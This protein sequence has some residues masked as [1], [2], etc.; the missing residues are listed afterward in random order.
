MKELIDKLFGWLGYVPRWY[1]LLQE[2]NEFFITNHRECSLDGLNY[3]TVSRRCEKDL[4]FGYTVTQHCLG[5][6]RC[7][8]VK[9]LPDNDD[10][11]YA[12][13]CAEELCEKLNE[14]Y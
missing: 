11:D 13:I 12:R 6:S 3:F 5:T 8:I 14:K 7:W 1:K 4:R 2:E 10:K 9:F